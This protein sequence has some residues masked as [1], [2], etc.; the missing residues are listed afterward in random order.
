MPASSAKPLRASV[1]ADA[2]SDLLSLDTLSAPLNPSSRLGTASTAP[3]HPPPPDLPLPLMQSYAQPGSRK[4][5]HLS[6]SSTAR[7]APLPPP[8]YVAPFPS[9]SPSF[10]P[11]LET[12]PW[13]TT[14]A[15][16]MQHGARAGAAPMGMSASAR[17]VDLLHEWQSSH[18]P[19]SLPLPLPPTS[20]PPPRPPMA[21]LPAATTSLPTATHPPAALP[22]SG[23]I[24]QHDLA[25]PSSGQLMLSAV[26]PLPSCR[27][28][29]PPSP[30]LLCPTPSP[31]LVPRGRKSAGMDPSSDDESDGD[32]D[33]DSDDDSDGNSDGNSDGSS[34]G[35]SNAADAAH[36]ATDG[37]DVSTHD[38]GPAD[39]NP[40]PG[41][42]A[43]AHIKAT[44]R[45]DSDDDHRGSGG[46]HGGNGEHGSDDGGSEHDSNPL[47]SAS[48]GDEEAGGY[49]EPR[50]P[51]AGGLMWGADSFSTDGAT[52]DD[53]QANARGAAYC[54]T[55][56][57]GGT[58][59]CGSYAYGPAFNAGFDR[60][61]VEDQQL[62]GSVGDCHGRGRSCSALAGDS[63]S[64]EEEGGA[65]GLERE[66]PG[67]DGARWWNDDGVGG[68]AKGDR[69]AR[70]W[71]R[72]DNQEG[73]PAAGDRLDYAD[74]DDEDKRCS[75]DSEEEEEEEEE[76]KDVSAIGSIAE[77]ACASASGTAPRLEG[78]TSRHASHSHSPVPV[79]SQAPLPVSMACDDDAGR[80][81]GARRGDASNARGKGHH[82]FNRQAS[83]GAPPVAASSTRVPAEVS[84]PSFDDEEMVDVNTIDEQWV[85]VEGTMPWEGGHVSAEDVTAFGQLSAW[86]CHSTPLGAP[87]VCT[88]PVP[89][90]ISVAPCRTCACACT[91]VHMHI[92]H[93][94][95]TSTC[96]LVRLRNLPRQAG[97]RV[98]SLS[99]PFLTVAVFACRS[100]LS[101]ESSTA[102]P[103]SRARRARQ[104]GT[105]RP[106]RCGE[107]KPSSQWTRSREMARTNGRTMA[108]GTPCAAARPIRRRRRH[109]PTLQPRAGA[110]CRPGCSC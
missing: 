86:L 66:W 33:D 90:A 61:E 32:S 83:T 98:P 27:G 52:V 35:N 62:H 99:R 8:S 81:N 102:P 77:A 54:S 25:L 87:R 30:P 9:S 28:P 17:T 29:P 63:D 41:H 103:R 47:E 6:P 11:D 43:G 55:Y 4:P 18:L 108:S 36:A 71:A 15:E 88:C 97:P 80:K 92:P 44:S 40:H 75:V 37:D 107:M 93:E 21:T 10:S 50:A 23:Q 51:H 105:N 94:T 7:E 65:P 53:T 69:V 70:R 95:C 60:V 106:T 74:S 72:A 2:F 73:V 45:S 104:L 58:G 68:G 12:D 89:R 91:L 38:D 48:E 57:D 3:V 34:D 5:V 26:P 84:T 31:E 67:F 1:P 14:P 16:D 49:T 64:D 19:S 39:C 13:Y 22:S 110:P 82:G 85:A 100:V 79:E 42:R 78:R 109:R 76:I 56:G 96:T 101:C 20:S 46:D 24:W 59:S